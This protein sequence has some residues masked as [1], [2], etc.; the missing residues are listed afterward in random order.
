MKSHLIHLVIALIIAGL[1]MAGYGFWYSVIS[2]KSADVASLQNQIV[3]KSE[4][5][6]RIASARAVLSEISDA[7]SA[8][9]SYFVSETGVVSF[10]EELEEQGRLQGT[11]VNVLSV[12]TNSKGMRPTITLS[13]TIKGSFDAVMRTVGA[14]EY[15]P[16]YLSVSGLSFVQND[17]NSWQADISLLVGSVSALHNTP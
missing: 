15:S 5:M 16:F 4:T 10:I 2:N 6:S 1:S 7:E 8:V 9:R 14:I 17:G 3:A 11:T 13:L 12:S